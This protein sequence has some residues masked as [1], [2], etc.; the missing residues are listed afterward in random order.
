MKRI[1]GVKRIAIAAV[2]AS[3]VL[4]LSLPRPAAA[5]IVPPNRNAI[6]FSVAT[7]SGAPLWSLGFSYGITH[8]LDVTAFYSYQS[9]SGASGSLLDAG[10]RYHFPVPTPGADVYV[11]AGVASVSTSVPGFTG[12]S[13]G[14]SIGAGASIRLTP[15]L[16]GYASGSV[17]SLSGTSNSIIDLGVMLQLAPRVSGQLGYL[18]F[19]GTGAPYLGINF[20]LP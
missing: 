20:S 7:F 15:I 14:I 4:S 6:N 3:S 5:Q 19:A 10:L 12:S 17:L 11:G 18:D 9:V 13:T 2:L 1:S 8:A 16:T